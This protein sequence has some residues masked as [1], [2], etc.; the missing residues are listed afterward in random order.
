[1]DDVPCVGEDP[2]LVPPEGGVSYNL[3]TLSAH[4]LSLGLAI[5]PI[6]LEMS[7]GR[8]DDMEDTL[9]QAFDGEVVVYQDRLPSIVK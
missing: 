3:I 7:D 1:M 5:L 4:G 8:V 9:G 6:V 2:L